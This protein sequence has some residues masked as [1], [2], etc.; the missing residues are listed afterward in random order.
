MATRKNIERRLKKFGKGLDSTSLS[1]KIKVAAGYRTE[2]PSRAPRG[3]VMIYRGSACAWCASKPIPGEWEPGV[4]AV[5]TEGNVYRAEGGNEYDGAERFVR[6]GGMDG[7]A[8]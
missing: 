3:F 7:G 8:A 4:F 5:D 2:N 6:V 1:E